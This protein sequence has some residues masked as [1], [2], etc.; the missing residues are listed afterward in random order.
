[1]QSFES[2]NQSGPCQRRLNHSVILFFFLLDF[3]VD[4][5]AIV[6]FQSMSNKHDKQQAAATSSWAHFATCAAYF[7][8]W[9]YVCHHR[10]PRFPGDK[11]DKEAEMLV[12]GSGE[13]GIASSLAMNHSIPRIAL[14]LALAFG[15]STRWLFLR[16][17][18]AVFVAWLVTR[19]LWAV[20][21][22]SR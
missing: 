6:A 18:G 22:L 10:L 16:H 17:T 15:Y 5:T 4:L 20:N 1:M 2:A 13:A 7:W 3:T 12:Y 11:P 14:I 8:I 19:M 21:E 9:E